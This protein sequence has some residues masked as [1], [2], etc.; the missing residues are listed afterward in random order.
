MT[1]NETH[2]RKKKMN[3]LFRELIE[4]HTPK[5]NPLIVNGLAQKQSKQGEGYIDSIFKIV[6]EKFPDGLEYLGY[7]RCTPEEEWREISRARSSK[8]EVDIA[9]S[10]IYMVK[11]LF[12]YDGV[13]LPPRYMYLPFVGEAGQFYSSGGRFF[14]APVLNNKVISPENKSLFVRLLRDKVVFEKTI[15]SII[16][17]GNRRSVQVVFSRFYRN[18]ESITNK[19][20]R[21]LTALG[22]YLFAKYGFMQTFDK[23]IGVRP[24]VGDANINEVD[25]PSDEWTIFQSSGFK[26]RTYVKNVYTP[27]TV[28]MAVRTSQLTPLMEELINSAYYVI[29]HFTSSCISQH[30]GLTDERLSKQLWRITLGRIIFQPDISEG[31]VYERLMEHFASIDEYI[32]PIIK[33]KLKEEGYAINDFYEF[34]VIIIRDFN[35]MVIQGYETN[36]SLYG[37]ELTTLYY[38][39]YPITEK[40]FKLAFK[41]SKD[42]K[43]KK[44][45]IQD[46]IKSMNQILNVRSIQKNRQYQGI[47]Q[48]SGYSGDNKF[49][50]NTSMMIPQADVNKR[51]VTKGKLNINDPMKR[52]H[53]SFAEAGGYLN[54]P[55]SNPVGYARIN[56]YTVIDDSGTIVPNPDPVIRDIIDRTHRRLISESNF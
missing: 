34:M 55:K 7:E 30:V 43:N 37:K 18:K 41:L 50:K 28:R 38:Q 21:A 17:N 29:D 45:S 33:L 31:L 1:V 23:F 8:K 51:G 40:I 48:T 4:K 56:P 44:L 25:Y 20:V 53:V 11:Y 3:E 14:I 10:D 49:F 32:D 35:V 19:T 52:F 47:F 39:F 12:R 22:H 54:L 16:K 36:N 9:R 42:Q 24:I 27:S 46:I 5:A 26:P 2:R 15:H 13:D 6:S